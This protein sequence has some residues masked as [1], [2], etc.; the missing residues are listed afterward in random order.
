MLKLKHQYFGHIMRRTDSLEKT[1]FLGKT[2]GGRRREWQRMRWL[3]GI[4]NSKDMSLSELWELLTA[5]E[6]WHAAVQGVAKSRAW[7]RDVQNW[8]AW[9][10]S[11]WCHPTVSSSVV[12][13]SSWLQCFPASGSFLMSQLFSSCGQSI[14]ASSASASVLPMNIQGWWDDLLCSE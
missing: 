13:F 9:L 10:L 2:E 6:A 12:S 14:G 8:T 1:L 3:K 11:R 7:L 5:R 4:I